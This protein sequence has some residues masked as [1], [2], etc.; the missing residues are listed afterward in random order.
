MPDQEIVRL[1]ETPPP[2]D[3]GT[4]RCFNPLQV[5]VIGFDH[6]RLA[7]QKE[8]EGG[9]SMIYSIGF[10][11]EGIPLSRRGRKPFASKSKWAGG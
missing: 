5:P 6:E 8:M 11:L 7:A 2:N 9:Y 10:A 3:Y 4:L 1:K